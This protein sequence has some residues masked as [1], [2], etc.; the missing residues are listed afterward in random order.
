MTPTYSQTDLSEMIDG[1]VHQKFNQVNDTQVIMN[2]AVRVVIS[3]MDMRSTKRSAPLSPNMFAQVFEYAAPSDLKGDKMIDIRRQVNRPFF[4]DWLL[5]DDDEFDK[6]KTVSRYRIALRD[7]NFARLLRI[8]GI[9]GATSVVMH[10]CQSLTT[11]GTWAATADAFNLTIDTTNA[12]RGGKALNWDMA[13]GGAT[14]FVE[15]TDSNDQDLTIYD[16]K[17][18]IFLWVFIPDYS[19]AQSDT[20][21]NFI[22]RWGNSSSAYWHRTVTTNNEGNIFHD[23]WNL[24]RFDWNG[25]TEVGTVDPTAMDYMR[26]TVTKSTSLEADTDW[27]LDDIVIRIGEIY[28]NVYYTKFGWQNSSGTYIEESTA[29]TDLVIAD[30]DEIEIIAFKGAE[31]AAQELK[32]YED[33]KYFRVQY[34]ETKRQYKKNNPSEALKK[35]RDYGQKVR[36]RRY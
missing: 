17:G 18:S 21:T 11:N 2:R 15:L 12:I 28:D 30:T 7:E 24:L 33:A 3:E 4:E 19:D 22:L 36:I 32:E 26:F 13:K 35:R 34:E 25:A 8:D 23:G 16:E 1:M 29:I 6:K 14:G 20:V 31:L 9:E 5:I 27:R 10:D